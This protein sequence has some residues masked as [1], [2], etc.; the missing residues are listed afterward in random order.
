[1]A[2]PEGLPMPQIA[3]HGHDVNYRDEGSGI[4]VLLGHSS[5]GSSGQWRE[6]FKRMSSRYRLVAPDQYRIRANRSILGWHPG[7]GAGNRWCRDAHAIDRAAG[8]SRGSFAR[9]VGARA[10]SR[11]DARAGA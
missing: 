4:A 1:M 11:P 3:M 6:L 9:R 10:R 2:F 5:T 8:P 7:N